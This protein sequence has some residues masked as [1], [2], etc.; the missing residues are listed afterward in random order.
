ME[1]PAPAP[2]NDSPDYL[3]EDTESE[4]EETEPQIRGYY[5][6]EDLSDMDGFFVKYSDESFDRYTEGEVINWGQPE[7]YT[8]GTEWCPANVVLH[9]NFDSLNM[10]SLKRGT[11]VFKTSHNA[12][13]EAGIYPVVESG[14]AMS[15][16]N[17]AGHG[18]KL[19]WFD[20]NGNDFWVV[21]GTK[22]EPQ[23]QY[24]FSRLREIMSINGISPGSAPIFE[25][26]D[27][28]T[29]VTLQLGD[30]YVIGEANGTKLIESE[31]TV[32]K[33]YYLSTLNFWEKPYE[34]S[35]TRYPLELQPTTDGY[36]VID[37]S[38]IPAGDYIIT[39]SY[40]NEEHDRRG[41]YI[42]HVCI[43]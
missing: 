8:Y 5:T 6:V 4:I 37:L 42:T 2:S 32:D 14:F 34:Y 16:F 28:K 23:Y 26:E 17:A 31:Y 1:A 9:A 24:H 13:V 35:E 33:K 39:Y 27:D 29:Y 38:N 41:A 7:Y 15:G 21:D 18:E 3:Q 30:T 43:E 25:K 12:K 11:L 19:F 10:E 22:I 20:E 36:A 40:W